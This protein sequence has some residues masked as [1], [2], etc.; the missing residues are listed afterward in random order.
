MSVLVEKLKSFD[1][2]KN[3]LPMYLQASDGFIS[4]FEIW[5]DLLVGQNKNGVVNVCDTILNLLNIFDA[6]FL[7]ELITIEGTEVSEEHPY[8]VKSD[9]LD[10]LALFFG[11]SRKFSCKYTENQQEFTKE[12][13]LDNEELLL[14]IKCQVLKANYDGT[15]EQ[16][17]S[18]YKDIGLELLVLTKDEYPLT[19]DLILAKID[20]AKQGEKGYHSENVN[21]MFKSN[22]LRV[23]SLG[24]MYNCSIVDLSSFLVWDDSDAN[25]KVW[26]KGTWSI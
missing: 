6:D 7:N 17:K 1:Y 11:F 2:Y 13:D 5:Y 25:P 23:E 18:F 14:L 21:I 8:G 15:Y 4:H 9:I 10:K 26:D 24:T 22:L 16:Y 3:K 20:G 19:V 12:L